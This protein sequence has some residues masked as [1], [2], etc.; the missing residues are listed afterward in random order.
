MKN[1]RNLVPQDLLQRVPGKQLVAD[2]DTEQ[3]KDK[4]DH[5]RRVGAARDR[6]DLRADG[7]GQLEQ[8]PVAVAILREVLVEGPVH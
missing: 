4:A 5:Q 3:V 8:G 7:H 6:H 2:L 1:W